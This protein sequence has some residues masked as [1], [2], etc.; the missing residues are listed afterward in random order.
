MSE[1]RIPW[2]LIGIALVIFVGFGF[3][4]AGPAGVVVFVL[5]LLL[6]ALITSVLGV[7]ACFVAAQI[8]STNFGTPKSAFVKLAAIAMFPAAAGLLVGLVSPIL[9]VVVLIV[10]FFGLLKS[11]FDLEFFELIVFVLVLWGVSWLAEQSIGW[12]Q[13]TLS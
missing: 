4:T 13:R 5:L 7:G 2:T 3:F 10:L 9:G 11:L 12:I 6:Q 8:L 1:T